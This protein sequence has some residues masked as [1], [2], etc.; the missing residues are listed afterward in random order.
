[1]KLWKGW[2]TRIGTRIGLFQILFQHS[3]K[4]LKYLRSL[5]EG[6][7]SS[8]ARRGVRFRFSSTGIAIPLAAVSNGIAILRFK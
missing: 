5:S 3:C 4:K 8:T 6:L 2:G 1:V 7:P